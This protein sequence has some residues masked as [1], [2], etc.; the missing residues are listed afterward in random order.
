MAP[1]RLSEIRGQKRAVELLLS[2]LRMGRV[3]HAW[4]FAG[5]DGVGKETTARAFAQSLLCETP[6]EGEACGGCLACQKVERGAHPDLL[7]VLPEARAVDRGL[8]SREELGRTPSR[9]L[10]IEQ[11][12]DLE[13]MLALAPV[14]AK[15]RVV[16]LVGADSMNVPAQNAFLKTLEE[17]PVGTHLVLLAETA[18]A[19]LPT[20]RSRC[21]RVPFAPL[22]LDLVAERVA[23]ARGVPEQ[24]A[25][26]L[27]A[28]AGGSLGRAMELT[29]EA[30]EDR[31]RILEELEQLDASDFRPLLALAERI[32]A[33]GRDG[34]EILLDAIALFYRDVAI[35]GEGGSE[36][37]VANRDLLP[38]LQRAARRGCPA[39]LFRY[40][41]AA[42]AREA[43]ERHAVPRLAVERFLIRCV[44]EEVAP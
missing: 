4:L 15:C 5:P 23:E 30:L 43:I 28:L 29:T 9:D 6:L 26:L 36:E 10:R 22:P 25:R 2:A 39:A 12:R 17:P 18:D 3:H 31:A 16:L 32:A 21:V 41:E 11:V 37:M 20:I 7:V 19:L 33:G 1:V 24:Q 40:R 13:G 34:A 27:A 44:L 42:R 38:L 8:L 14:E 35:L